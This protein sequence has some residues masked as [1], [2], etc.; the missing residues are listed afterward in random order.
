VTTSA[1]PPIVKDNI[2][3]LG[4]TNASGRPVLQL[5]GSFLGPSVPWGGSQHGLTIR[6]ANHCTIQGL[7][8]VGFPDDGIS[9]WDAD[10]AF[11]AQ[12]YL[13]VD[14]GGSKRNPNRGSYDIDLL[15]ATNP[16][17]WWS[18][19]G[20]ANVG[21]GMW[22][23]SDN[24]LFDNLFGL[25]DAGSAV[26][27][28]GQRGVI[29]AAG[30][31]GCKS[32]LLSHN[33]FAGVEVGVEVFHQGTELNRIQNNLFG[34]TRDGTKVLPGMS[35]GIYVGGGA[36]HNEIGLET[37]GGGSANVF[38][39]A[40]MTGV[41]IGWSGT[42]DNV[43]AG[44]YFGTNG[45]GTE[46]RPL[47][48]G[49]VI[50]NKAGQ[51]TIGGTFAKY[52]NLFV[53]SGGAGASPTGVECRNA[54][55]SSVIRFN[56]FGVLPSGAAPGR[57]NTGV[58]VQNAPSVWVADNNFAF[59]ETAVKVFG[60]T[61]GAVILRNRFRECTFAAVRLMNAAHAYL[62]DFTSDLGPGKNLFRLTNLWTIRNETPNAVKAEGNDFETTA[63]ASI[64][65]K[66]WDRLDDATLGLVDYN[67]LIG[68]VAPT[69]G[70]EGVL[71]V[72][73][74]TALP[75]ATGA[76]IAFALSSPATVTVEVLNLAGRP[77]ALLAE[78]R[79]ADA[80]SQRLLWTGRT[81]TGALAPSGPY[82]VRILAHDD[83]GR[84]TTAM[85]PLYLRR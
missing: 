19:L 50:D 10:D 58:L 84:K 43:V 33:V 38:A 13:G 22:D 65:P 37:N 63:K 57:M 30:Q 71:A 68:G 56:R 61:G 47:L 1:L 40:G 60:S 52:G 44:N 66:I 46:Q 15:R 25:Q 76:E 8:I 83:T 7:S 45:A 51:Q 81:A 49:V 54:G 4:L 70:A 35:C 34:L 16:H 80:G 28:Q 62:G 26:L 17:L 6:G 21:V 20:S 41:Q 36:S 85:A 11:V 79:A 2:Q 75:T 82:L 12:C 72:T 73:S 78:E 32:N 69:G 3:I 29:L 48:R 9:I 5:D 74:A 18:V 27:G 59:P 53:P 39:G 77:V 67:P 55:G 64:N 14:L 23:C 31:T 24:D 42:L